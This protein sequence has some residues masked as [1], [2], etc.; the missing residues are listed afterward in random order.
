[1]SSKVSLVPVFNFLTASGTQDLGLGQTSTSSDLPSVTAFSVGLG[2]NY[3]V[4]D[5]LLAGGLSLA[6]ASVTN[7]STQT[8]P[9]LTSSYFI[10]PVWNVG[11]EWNLTDW[12]VGRLGYIATTVKLTN[13]S[14][15]TQTPEPSDVNQTIQTLFIGPNGAT[16]GVGFRF[17]DFSIDATVNEGVL[18]QGLNNIGGGGPTFAYMSVSYALP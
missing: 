3:T 6:N 13:E 1:M 9:E 4:G 10:F 17:G 14:P 5:F 8:T 18:R 12:L 15:A 16:V 2:A 7:A 11:L